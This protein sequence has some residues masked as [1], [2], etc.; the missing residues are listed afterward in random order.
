MEKQ[1]ITKRV[2]DAAG[3]PASGERR[4]WDSEIAGFCLRVYPPAR[5]PGSDALTARKVFAIKYRVKGLQRWLNLGE[6]GDGPGKLTPDKARLHA[7]AVIVDAR[8]GIDAS[9]T[10][11]REE[12]LTVGGLID[13]YLLEGPKDKRDKRAASWVQDKTNL[14]RHVRPL[15]GSKRADA[16]TRDN[17]ERMILDV[18]EGKTARDVKT[19]KRGRSIVTGGA[20]V[21]DRT[22]STTRA[23]FNWAIDKGVIEGPNP[24][25][26]VKRTLSASVERFLTDAE[27][28]RLIAT[29]A[30]LEAEAIVTTKQASIFRLLLLTGARRAEIAGLRW[31]EVDFERKRLDLPIERTKAG[32]KNG[33]RRIPLNA[34]AIAILRDLERTKAARARYVFPATKGKSGHT[35]SEAKVWREK[36]ITR[37]KLPGLRIHDLRHS[38]ASFALADGASLYLIGKALGHASSRTTERYAHLADDPVRDMAETVGK[39]FAPAGADK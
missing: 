15:L 24:C 28:Q 38:F 4:I 5:R 20:G 7:G 3:P 16:V 17:I 34:P 27:A 18:T 39:R 22:F 31:S 8:R 25:A 29:L 1:K 6:Y 35:T 11:K 23:M 26:K 36:V 9:E 14:E 30:E 33:E 10:R 32:G 21:A 13:R 19:G 2:V 37:A 12:G